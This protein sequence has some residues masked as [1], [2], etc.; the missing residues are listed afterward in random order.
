MARTSPRPGTVSNRTPTGKLIKN[1]L[2]IQHV[3][4]FST[5]LRAEA[6]ALKEDKEREKRM[7]EDERVRD[8][9]AFIEKQK[10]GGARNIFMPS[11]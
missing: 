7:L 4:K 10:T 11:Y 8:L 9:Q 1:P 3:D 6:K 2:K 5:D